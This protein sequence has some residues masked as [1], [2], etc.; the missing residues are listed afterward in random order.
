[1]IF[2]IQENKNHSFRLIVYFYLLLRR[3]FFG[4]YPSLIWRRWKKFACLFSKSLWKALS[5]FYL[6]FLCVTIYGTWNIFVVCVSIS[7][8][9]KLTTSWSALLDAFLALLVKVLTWTTR[10]LIDSV[11]EHTLHDWH[12]PGTRHLYLAPT[13][14]LKPEIFRYFFL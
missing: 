7:L 3:I 1:M 4:N 14:Y 2:H 11:I 9:Q 5:I 13:G 10:H 8:T 6:L 12:L